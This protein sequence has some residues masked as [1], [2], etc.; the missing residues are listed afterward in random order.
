MTTG[1]HISESSLGE[2]H[3]SNY[4]PP[5]L[6]DPNPDNYKILRYSE[7]RGCL[8]IEL[9]FLDCVNYEGRKILVFENCTINDL[10]K[11]KNIDPHFSDSK[12]FKSPVSRFEPSERG[13]AWAWKFVGNI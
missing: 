12:E 8:I 2:K 3:W 9:Q 4:K 5:P 7:I 6:P 10:I 1:L 13:W 11:Q